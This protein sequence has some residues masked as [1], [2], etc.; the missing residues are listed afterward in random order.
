MIVNAL[1]ADQPQAAS[2]HLRRS[3]ATLIPL[4]QKLARG[5]A[6][7]DHLILDLIDMADPS[8]EQGKN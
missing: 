3:A 8:G 5:M 1:L 6:K 2:A 4:Q 7:L